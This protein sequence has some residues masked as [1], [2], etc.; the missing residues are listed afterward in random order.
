VVGI[1]FIKK[2]NFWEKR[3]GRGA[4]LFQLVWGIETYLVQAGLELG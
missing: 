4:R 1:K 2:I 3:E